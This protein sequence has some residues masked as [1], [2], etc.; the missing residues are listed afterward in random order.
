M[1]ARIN[2][3]INWDGK[4]YAQVIEDHPAQFCDL[5]ALSE[6]CQKVLYKELEYENSPMKICSDLCNEEQTN[7][8]MF[9]EANDAERYV[10]S[11]NSHVVSRR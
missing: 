4:E 3:I 11:R 5:C 6:I 8:A 2:K 1:I 10:N 9:I 7:F